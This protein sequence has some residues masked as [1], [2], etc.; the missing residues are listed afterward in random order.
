MA[1]EKKLPHGFVIDEQGRLVGKIPGGI[2]LL[3]KR[4]FDFVMREALT[5]DLL[6][7]ELDADLT[8][9]LHFNAELMVRQ[10]VSVGDFTGPFTVNMLRSIKPASWRIL[11]T[12]QGVLDAMGE[13]EPASAPAS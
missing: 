13:A 7:A 10:L 8:K 1:E 9:V 11:R 12:A 2:E 3:G 6:D 4:H 5:G